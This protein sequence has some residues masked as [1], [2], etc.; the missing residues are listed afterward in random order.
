MRASGSIREAWYNTY[1]KNLKSCPEL[2]I[3]TLSSY[4][5]VISQQRD[6]KI[7]AAD[8]HNAEPMS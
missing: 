7:V 4:V 6:M 1:I 3:P 2:G 5:R 8:K